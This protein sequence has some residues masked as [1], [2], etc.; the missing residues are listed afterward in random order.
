MKKIISALLALV[1]SL[2]LCACTRS[3]QTDFTSV[4]TKNFISEKYSE[5]ELRIALKVVYDRFS[6]WK[7]VRLISVEY[8][9]DER[10]E[11]ELDYCRGINKKNYADCIVF[12]S[13]YRT[14]KNCEPCLEPFTVYDG[15]NWI[16]A[17]EKNGTWELV[18]CGY[19]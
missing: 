13:A 9:G 1:L 6:T 3:N 11:G 12:T 4:R 15:Y 7:G 19:A 17:R 8:M 10:S 16:I 18:T 14:Y 2:S 5:F